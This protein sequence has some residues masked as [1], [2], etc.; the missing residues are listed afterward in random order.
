MQDREEQG[1]TVYHREI[2][3]GNLHGKCIYKGLDIQ[4]SDHFAVCLKL[5]NFVSQLYYKYP[6]KIF[7]NR[8][9]HV[10]QHQ[11]NKIPR[12]KSNKRSIKFVLRRLQN[13]VER[14]YRRPKRMG[15]HPVFMDQRTSDVKMKILTKLVHRFNIIIKI[16]ASFFLHKSKNYF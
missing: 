16:Q 13:I 15:K 7:K 1:P 5:M 8:R 2:L 11:K 6:N 12:D 9:F 4:L 10:Q 14:N 3:C